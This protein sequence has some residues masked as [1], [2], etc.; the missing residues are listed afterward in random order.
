MEAGEGMKALFAIPIMALLVTGA[1]KC[2]CSYDTIF[3]MM[4]LMVAGWMA[5]DD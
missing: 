2:G 4:A 5:N 3:L 1:F